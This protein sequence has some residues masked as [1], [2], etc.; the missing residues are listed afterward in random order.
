MPDRSDFSTEAGQALRELLAGIGGSRWLEAAPVAFSGQE[1][2]FGSP[3]RMVTATAAALGATAAGAAQRW[4]RASGQKQSIGID[5]L[6]AA[7]GLCSNYFQRQNGHPVPPLGLQR[8]LKAGFYATADQRWFYLT[9]SYPHLRDGAL[10]LL[11]CANTPAAIGRAVALRQSAELEEAFA[12]RGLTGITTRS[13]GEW[14]RHP[15]GALLACSPVISIEKIGDSPAEPPRSRRRPLD[16]LR[17]IDAAHV[18]AGPVAAR[19]LAEHGAEVLRVSS[20]LQPDPLLQLLDT[21]IGKR[22]AY[23]DLR[24]AD[25]A[26]R[27][28]ELVRRAD[29]FVQS[30][31][32]TSLDRLGF[33]PQALAQL[34]PGLIYL[35][36][37]AFGDGPWAERK[38]FDQIAQAVTGIA[39]TEGG[40]GDGGKP[41]LVP[42]HLLN[43]FLSAYLGAAGVMAALER[44]A[45]EGGSWHVRVSLAR[46]AMYVQD[47]GLR[48]P[49]ADVVH[50]DKLKPVLVSHDSPF[51][52]IERMDPV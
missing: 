35:S 3:H 2:E 24:A 19:T 20:P 16:D 38:G 21:G 46:S 36:V 41:R 39:L 43:D 30:W 15:Q 45:T 23:I 28:R 40:G 17:V 18:I 44:R 12:A 4:A 32:P 25:D 13:T 34:R 50:I 26:A 8:E 1:P 11:D 51:G 22:N 6:H 31:K 5:A 52:I 42:T 9:G 48:T 37:S 7:C 29:V 27:L 49:G 47:L 33:G 14:R 10:E